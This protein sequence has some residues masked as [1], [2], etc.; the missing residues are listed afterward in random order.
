VTAGEPGSSP[1]ASSQ[2]EAVC[3]TGPSA[4]Y[5]WAVLVLATAM[6]MGMSMPQQ[7]PAA[8]GPVLTDALHLSRAQLGLLTSAIWGGMLLGML[9]FGLLIDRRG[10]RAVVALG[11]LVLA[12]FLLLAAQASSFLPLFLLLIPAAVGASCAG[13]G[14]TR[15]IAAWFPGHQRG[16]ALGIRQTGVTAAGIISAIAL[17]PLAVKLGWQAPFRSVAGLALLSALVFSLFYREPQAGRRTTMSPLDVGRLLRSRTFLLAT[18]YGWIFMGALGA[19][20]T[21]LTVSLHQQQGLSAVDAGFFLGVLQLGGVVGRVGWG[22]LSDRLG[23][24]GRTMSLAGT[25]T[26]AAS[27][28]LAVLGHRAVPTL[29]LGALVF[30]LGISALGWNTIYIALCAEAGPADRAATVVGLGTTVTFT[31][32]VTVTPLFGLIADRSGGFVLSWTFLAALTV[33]GVLLS[34]GVRDRASRGP[35]AANRIPP[36]AAD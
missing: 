26:V 1:A 35:R 9:P 32:M 3:P 17:P 29:A 33:V 23:S 15:A 4:T 16:M 27:L 21:Y 7:T 18:G 10:E 13:P 24:R 31:G 34:L 12:A 22:M 36:L 19:A 6:Q 28:A 11:A 20:I 30:V 2:A 5:R 14:G 8:I 25:V